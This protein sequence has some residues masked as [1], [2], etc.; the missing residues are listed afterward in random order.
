MWNVCVFC[1]PVALHVMNAPLAFG[2]LALLDVQVGLKFVS[3]ET[4]TNLSL[5]ACRPNTEWLDLLSVPLV[6]S[7]HDHHVDVQRHVLRLELE[8]VVP[9]LAPDRLGDERRVQRLADV[10]DGKAPPAGH[11]DVVADDPRAGERAD[12]VRDELD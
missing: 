8:R 2:P 9:A 10:V 12:L 1:Q 6:A 7:E 11:V 3:P 4:S 5:P